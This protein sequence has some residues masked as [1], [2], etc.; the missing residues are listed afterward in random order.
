MEPTSI[1]SAD[2]FAQAVSQQNAID[3]GNPSPA[4]VQQPS[5]PEPAPQPAPAEHPKAIDP[6]NPWESLPPDIA[7]EPEVTPT[8]P[9]SDPSV[10]P[11][12][13][14]AKLTWKTLRAIEA[15]HKQLKPQY[16]TLKAE[17]E[18]LRQNQ[19]KLPEDIQREIEELRNFQAATAIEQTPEWKTTVSQPVQNLFARLGAVAETTKVSYDELVQLSN[20]PN[21]YLRNK[22]IQALMSQ[23]GGE[24]DQSDL[25]EANETCSE[26][27]KVYQ[28]AHS[29][30]QKAAEIKTAL[31][32]K[33]TLESQQKTQEFQQKLSTSA[34]TMAERFKASLKS[35]D[36]LSEQILQDVVSVRP[37]DINTE[38]EMAIYQAQAGKLVPHLIT[39]LQA[40][41]KEL[42]A[43]KKILAA[44]GAAGAPAIG[45]AQNNTPPVEQSAEEA[46]RSA[47]AQMP[48]YGGY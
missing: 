15:E 4:P 22:K 3:A 24:F 6:N 34:S 2:A 45:A 33:Q 40:A 42:A 9:E 12:E 13:P 32:G 25:L 19:G 18:Q 5:N 30:K 47:M 23:D 1:S 48:R 31:E 44:R 16:E 14:K 20:E 39:K 46:L 8:E 26:L 21:G 11:T 7:L 17:L 27:N 43:T 10:E 28:H 38:P 29:L 36:I 35:T 41:T 37:A